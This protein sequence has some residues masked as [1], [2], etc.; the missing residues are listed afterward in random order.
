MAEA[1]LPDFDVSAW[2]GIAAPAGLN[3][4]VTARIGAVLAKIAVDP[5]IVAVM[6]SRGADVPDLPA[7]EA[8]TFLAADTAKWQQVPSYAKIQTS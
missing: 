5:Q 3:A 7:A 8:A 6:Q 2:Y 1:G 4:A